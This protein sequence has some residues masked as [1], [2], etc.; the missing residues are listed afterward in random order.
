MKNIF[1]GNL[2]YQVSESELRSAFEQFGQVLNV[3]T[4]TDRETGRARGF[5]F[6][7]AA[8]T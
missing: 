6:I 4:V 8:G 7:E 1:V 2:S 5:A 3:N